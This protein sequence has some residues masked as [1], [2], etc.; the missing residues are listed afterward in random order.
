MLLVDAILALPRLLLLLLLASLFGSDADVLTLALRFLYGVAVI[1]IARATTLDF[2]ARD[3]VLAA[4]AMGARQRTIT[5]RELLPN[6]LDILVVEGALR[7]SWMLLSF[8]THIRGYHSSVTTF[9][10]TP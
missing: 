7:W 6:V 9:A 5:L 4:Y 1:R 10:Y 2:V 8:R 3:F